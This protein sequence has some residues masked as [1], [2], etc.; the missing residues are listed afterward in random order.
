[1]LSSKNSSISNDTQ[2]DS[3]NE[4]DINNQSDLIKKLKSKGWKLYGA[5]WCG[6]TQ[7]QISELGGMNK[8]KS[9]YVDC[10]KDQENVEK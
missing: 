8:I 2:E 4:D 10:V 5:E 6:W 1:M 3:D 9:I 7:K